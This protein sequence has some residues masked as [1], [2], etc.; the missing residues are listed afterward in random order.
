[1]NTQILTKTLYS[2]TVIFFP[3]FSYFPFYK[4]K[5]RLML[6]LRET[7]PLESYSTPLLLKF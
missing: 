6:V 5:T 7:A 3:I 4:K 1:M 2:G